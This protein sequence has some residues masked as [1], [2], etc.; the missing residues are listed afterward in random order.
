MQTQ[1]GTPSKSEQK[2]TQWLGYLGLIPF[3]APLLEMLAAVASSSGIQSAV[4]LGFYAPYVFVAYS[5]VILS[6]LSGILWGKGRRESTANKSNMALIISNLISILAW[7]SLLMIHIS[8][9]MTLFA[10]TLLMCGYASLLLAERSV[11]LS[12]EAIGY[13]RMRLV[14]TALVIVAHCLTL[15]LL[16]KDV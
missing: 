10:V 9:L 3:I 4:F 7:L 14:L 8:A 2:L 13:W 6:F 1:L 5:A 16:I 12:N 11:G 15:I